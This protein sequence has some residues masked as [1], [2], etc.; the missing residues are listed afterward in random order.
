MK[1]VNE[2]S[3]ALNSHGD[4]GITTGLL[5]LLVT[6]MVLAGL[7]LSATTYAREMQYVY[8]PLGRVIQVIYDSCTTVEYDYDAAGNVTA[9]RTLV[10]NSLDADCDNVVDASDACA[11]TAPG[12]VVDAQG[13]TVEQG[14]PCAGPLSG[15]SWPDSSAYL[16]CV[17]DLADEL[18]A[19]GAIT[20]GD[21]NAIVAR[22]T[23]DGDSDGV[24]NSC[25]NCLAVMNTNQRDTDGDKIGNACD[26]DI[27]NDCAVNF[28]DLA[29]YKANFFAIGDL[30]TDND[31]DGRTNFNDLAL[32]KA[33]FFGPPGPSAEGCN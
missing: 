21:R 3:N 13:C 4:F 24:A 29:I 28:P 27:T 12:A 32:V 8:D 22:A 5:Q 17:T 14:C 26:A 23:D 31:G 20:S 19:A 11:A 18:L 25:D 6:F 10:D 1:N 30:H 7:L 33:G 2:T 15:G 9:T 16:M